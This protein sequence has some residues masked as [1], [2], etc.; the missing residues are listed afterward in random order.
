MPQR[1]EAPV[2]QVTEQIQSNLTLLFE[3]LAIKTAEYSCNGDRFWNF[4]Q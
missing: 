3:L 2:L 1:I 4:N